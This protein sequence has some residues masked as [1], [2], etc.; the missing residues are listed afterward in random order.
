MKRTP[1]IDADILLY[2]LGFSSQKGYGADAIPASWEFVEE[3]VAHKLKIICEESESTEEPILYL[4]NTRKVSK[5]LNKKRK[6]DGQEEKPFKENFRMEVAKEKAYK[7]TRVSDKPF[8]YRNLQEYFMGNFNCVVNE[9]GLEADDAMC[10]KQYGEF[11]SGEHSTI[12]CSRDKDLWQCP[13]WHYSW[14]VGKQQAKGPLFVEPLGHLEHLNQ[15]QVD[16]KGRKV[17]PKIF[18]TGDL[19]L[20]YQM[21]VGDAVDNIGGIKGRGPA[22]GYNLLKDAK[23][24]REA[25]ELV[26]ELYVKAYNDNWFEKLQ[27]QAYLVYMI[28]EL[29]DNGEKVLWT[30]PPLG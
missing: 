13:G 12:I 18:G 20:Y 19:F 8:H 24:A 17:P 25:Y 21:I 27:E 14:E 6:R 28:R 5:S 16:A 7:G 26:A 4:T 29:D 3:L 30:P 15:G 22:F 2:E 1:L 9:D 11:K 23:S 10:I